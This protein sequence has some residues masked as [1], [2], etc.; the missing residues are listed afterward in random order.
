MPQSSST[1]RSV[2]IT[3]LAWMT[4]SASSRAR[5]IVALTEVG[6]HNSMHAHIWVRPTSEADQP[7]GRP[8]PLA[9]KLVP[10][11]GRSPTPVEAAR[12]LLCTCCSAAAHASPR[13]QRPEATSR[14]RRRITSCIGLR[15][16]RAYRNQLGVGP[17]HDNVEPRRRRTHAARSSTSPPRS[18]ARAPSYRLRPNSTADAVAE[19][20]E[21][22]AELQARLGA[23]VAGDATAGLLRQRA[24]L[25]LGTFKDRRSGGPCRTGT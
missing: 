24:R 10:K 19:N 13:S 5:P 3:S 18:R 23:P 15:P 21:A 14:V 11:V 8:S 4:R 17:A 9:A 22:L 25:L 6:L 12:A 20:D 1:S 16:T 7:R 2:R